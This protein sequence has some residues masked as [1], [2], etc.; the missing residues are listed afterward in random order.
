MQRELAATALAP[1][2]RIEGPAIVEEPFATHFTA[3]GWTGVYCGCGGF[4]GVVTEEPQ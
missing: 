2:D 1:D 3:A 4:L